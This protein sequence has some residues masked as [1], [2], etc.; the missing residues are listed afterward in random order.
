M[1]NGDGTLRYVRSVIA[2]ESL[3]PLI[4]EGY[5]LPRPV[6]C[7]LAKVGDNDNYYVDVGPDRE[8]RCVLRLLRADKHWLPAGKEE[9]Y[10][11]FEI[12]WLQYAHARGAPVAC[13]LTRR[14]GELV[15]S[16]AA[17]EGR[18][19]WTLFTYAPGVD[20]PIDARGSEAYGKAVAAL[21]AASAG[22]TSPYDR[23]HADVEFLV[24]APAR[25]AEAFL[26][27]AR[28]E[29]V[30]LLWHAAE[31]VRPWFDRI[32]RT[33]DTYGVIAGDTH[34]GNKL[35]TRDGRLT[36]IDSDICGWG[37]RA[38]DAATFLWDARLRDAEGTKWAPFVRG[39]ESVRPFL[40]EEHAAIPWF[41]LARH[42][43]ALGAHAMY[44]RHA[45]IAPVGP[46]FWDHA[47][48]FMRKW[49]AAMPAD[50]AA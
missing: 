37:W 11:R 9:E 25:Q 3:V 28:P 41:A 2:G 24:E 6:E 17:A 33:S 43:W 8:R 22:F 29:D 49:L 1:T 7:R 10:L 5:D 39:Y 27:G 30:K 20:G 46:F 32:P 44:A 36:L 40:E 19:Y 34:G 12:A 23:L 14:D 4:E 38:Y 45:G 50:E 47:F 18:R 42:I 16:V 21:H 48:R 15:G 35:V 13:P 31:R 26:G